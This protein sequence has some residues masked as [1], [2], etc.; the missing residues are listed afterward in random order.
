MIPGVV[1]GWDGSDNGG[2]WDGWG[3]TGGGI[4]CHVMERES[5]ENEEVAKLL[6]RHFIPIKV[7]REERPDIDRIY[8]NFVSSR[9]SWEGG[10]GGWRLILMVVGINRCKLQLVLEAGR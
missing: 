5:F 1:G 4:G 2:G 7:D 6:N 10:G 8:M 9:G 3:L